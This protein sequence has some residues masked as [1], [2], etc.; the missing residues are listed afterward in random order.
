MVGRDRLGPTAVLKSVSR[1]DNT[2]AVNGSLLNLKF[3]PNT[4]RG[5]NG[6]KKFADFLMTFTQ[7]K[8]RH[9]QFNVQSR[10]TLIDAQ[11]HPEN[12]AGLVVRVAGYSAF[13]VDLNKHIQDDIIRRAE[14]AL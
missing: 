2:L 10:E 13:F 1:I 3:S 6:I 9:V 8:I 11:K 5:E 12:Y 4:L 7:L 14:H